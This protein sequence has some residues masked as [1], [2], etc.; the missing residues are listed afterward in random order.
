M[1]PVL[2]VS[3]RGWREERSERTVDDGV[4]DVNSLRAEFASESLT[5][6]GIDRQWVLQ[7]ERVYVL[8]P[9]RANLEGANAA[10]LAPPAFRGASGF[11][12]GGRCE[13]RTLDSGGSSREDHRS[14][15]LV[16]EHK[17][18]DKLGEVEGAHAVREVSGREGRGEGDEHVQIDACL[19]LGC[20]EV[21]KWLHDKGSVC[22]EAGDLGRD[23]LDLARGETQESAHLEVMIGK[24]LADLCECR[25][26]GFGGRSIAGERCGLRS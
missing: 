4:G 7:G 10:N 12:R 3:K 20:L 1:N 5:C 15:R 9:R 2:F 6:E 11:A 21:E 22:V 23:S 13:G 8:S 16:F 18:Y 19:H 26:E 17:R 14:S 25:S 24:G